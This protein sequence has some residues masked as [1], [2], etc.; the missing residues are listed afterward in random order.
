MPGPG[1]TAAP[2]VGMPMA[3]PAAL[4]RSA[5]R[6]D[7]WLGPKLVP[8]T[9]W[10]PAP[11]R[12]LRR[13]IRRLLCNATLLVRPAGIA[14]LRFQ[15]GGR[16][17]LL[18]GEDWHRPSPWRRSAQESAIGNCWDCILGRTLCGQDAVQAYIQW[19]NTN[20]EK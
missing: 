18:D 14:D 7:C 2:L 17:V 8:L 13:L 12:A 4:G 3:G 6:A 20:L 9:T 19:R 5:L 11:M 10:L 1:T 15:R 16:Q